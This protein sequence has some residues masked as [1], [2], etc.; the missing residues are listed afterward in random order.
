[1]YQFSNN[2]QKGSASAR[3]RRDG[4]TLPEMLISLGIV[5]VILTVVLTNQATYTDGAALA[6]LA[7]NISLSVSQAQVYGVSVREVTPGSSDFS[8]AY[9]LDFRLESAGGS[10]D[11]YIFFADKDLD[12]VYDSGWSCPIDSS[13][14]DSSS[15]CLD[16]T[17][18]T[19]GNFIDSLCVIYIDD[20]EDC[21]L[22]RLTITFT[23]P[24]TRARLV[25]YNL[26]GGLTAP[27]NVKGAR[28]KVESPAGL[29][30]AVS[31]YTTGYISTR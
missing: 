14:D 9:G 16:K 2:L 29:T 31:V 27:A 28:I 18:I 19:G 13:S 20:T 10:D 12:Q 11:A 21:D 23:R 15:E 7:D 1:M 22:G 24:D 5:G 25:F 6:N 26:S 8:S 30:R 17:E 4:F 3:R